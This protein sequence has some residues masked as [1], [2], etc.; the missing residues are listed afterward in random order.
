MLQ[1]ISR[2]VKT[3]LCLT[4]DHEQVL[5]EIILIFKVYVKG[6]GRAISNENL[7]FLQL[8]VLSSPDE[9]SADKVTLFCQ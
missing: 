2:V 1:S 7:V 3:S 5:K 9:Y 6:G 4:C 8:R